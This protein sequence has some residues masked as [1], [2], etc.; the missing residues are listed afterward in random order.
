L[1]TLRH[2][3]NNGASVFV[4]R[5]SG[6]VCAYLVS[7]NVPALDL[8]D[9]SQEVLFDAIR[10]IRAGQFERRAAISTWLFGIARHKAA[11]YW[12]AR[13]RSDRPTLSLRTEDV[14]RWT[15]PE[16]SILLNQVIAGLPPAHAAIFQRFHEDCATIETIA[17][18]VRLSPRR[19]RA[20]LQRIRLIVEN[21]FTD[22][23]RTRGATTRLR[24]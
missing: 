6:T 22:T 14:G 23:N 4:A 5:F 12:R 20:I 18:E 19:V 16:L 8:G 2:D 21:A 7:L 13:R 11:D 1:D 10:Q 3:L 9:V 24:R 17:R 15:T